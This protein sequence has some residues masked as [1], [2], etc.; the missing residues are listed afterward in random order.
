M[1]LTIVKKVKIKTRPPPP[2][3]PANKPDTLYC[4]TDSSS[5]FQ[6]GKVIRTGASSFKNGP[7]YYTIEEQTILFHLQEKSPTEEEYETSGGGLLLLTIT[8]MQ[9]ERR[10][11]RER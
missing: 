2:I 7:L 3:F 9:R 10:H 5:H 11:K 8:Q 4:I 6:F 1:S